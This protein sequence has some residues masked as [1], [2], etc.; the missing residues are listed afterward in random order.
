MIMQGAWDYFAEDQTY[1]SVLRQ[2]LADGV[3]MDSAKALAHYLNE[4][5][6]A[7]I[8][9][10]DF[11]GGPGHYYPVLKHRYKNGHVT[12]T[13]VDTDV[14]NIEHGRAKFSIDNGDYAFFKVGSVLDPTASY[15]EHNCIVSCNTLPHIP[16]IEPL[17]SFLKDDKYERQRIR[18]FVFRMLIGSECV[19]IKKHLNASSF[20]DIFRHSYQHNNIYSAEYLADRLG[21]HWLIDV[22]PD[23]WDADRMSS[24]LLKHA[25][26]DFHSNR[27]SRAEGDKVFKGDIFM[28]WRFVLGRR[29]L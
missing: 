2:R 16:T 3:E 24:H 10:L 4:L 12:Y 14:D 21:K 20:A 23:V 5:C 8:N 25:L 1:S 22:R 15:G 7:D 9:I 18:Y 26:S 19:E 11:G 28:P 27:V 13:S 6:E 17:L 29:L